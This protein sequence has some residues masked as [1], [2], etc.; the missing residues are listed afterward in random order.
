MKSI[1]LKADDRL[2]DTAREIAAAEHT[3]LGAKFREWLEDYASQAKSAGGVAQQRKRQA[4]RAM[5]TV[6]ELRRKYPPQNRK[7]TREEM[8]ERG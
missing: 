4:E 8:N 2:I 7:F 5:S 3:T 6:R 1:T